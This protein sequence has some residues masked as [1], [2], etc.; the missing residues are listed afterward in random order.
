MSDESLRFSD[1]IQ[2]INV[3]LHHLVLEKI[4]ILN[5]QGMIQFVKLYNITTTPGSTV[6][7]IPAYNAGDRGSIPRWGE[8]DFFSTLFPNCSG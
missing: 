3:H 6:A 1:L 4:N 8:C 7:S 2:V 5:R